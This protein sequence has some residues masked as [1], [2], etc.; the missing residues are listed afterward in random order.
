MIQMP[1]FNIDLDPALEHYAGMIAATAD[2]KVLRR[3]PTIGEVWCQSSPIVDRLNMTKV[4]VLDTET[5]G[6][7]PTRDKIIELAFVRM[8]IC[9]RTGQLLH[10]E[11]PMSFL[12]DPGAPLSEAIQDLTG[13]SDAELRGHRF[14]DSVI[15]TMLS[16]ACL[17][18]GHNARFDADFVRRRFPALT[19]P[20]GCS[21][22]DIDWNA[23]GLAA[24]GK[25]VGALLAAAGYFMDGAHRAG[26]DTWATAI[27]LSMPARDGRTLAAHLIETARRP[28]CRLFAKGAPFALKDNLRAAG[29]R[30]CAKE[31]AWW[32]EG[33]PEQ[34]DN[35]A[36]WLVQ[37][38]PAILPQSLRIDHHNRHMS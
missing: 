13:L 30:W 15:A 36:A 4:I 14:D 21:L 7:D 2:Y 24:N 34:M 22:I 31:R 3:L 23:H 33:D 16:D 1:P 5:T 26:P 6:L 17:L 29:Y 11:P 8:T 25:S 38:C 12:E 18:V 37:L 9:D 35:E 32:T 27:L 19:Q 20:W 28:S 10:I